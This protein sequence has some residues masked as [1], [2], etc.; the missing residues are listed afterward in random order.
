MDMAG[1]QSTTPLTES[2]LDRE[3]DRCRSEIANAEQE[4]RAGHLDIQ[5][6]CLAIYDWSQELRILQNEQRRLRRGGVFQSVR[7]W[8]GSAYF[9]KSLISQAMR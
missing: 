8:R 7:S 5:G 4:I 3:M 6:L 1:P 2:E 9:R